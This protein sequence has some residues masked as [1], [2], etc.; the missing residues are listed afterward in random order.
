[1]ALG[2]AC[3][4]FGCR[5]LRRCFCHVFEGKGKGETMKTVT[6]KKYRKEDEK[7]E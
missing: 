4:C 3:C 5:V 1:M 6:R 2:R 7:R